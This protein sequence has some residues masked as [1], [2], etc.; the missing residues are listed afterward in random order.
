MSGLTI[1]PNKDTGKLELTAEV[2]EN[3]NRSRVIDNFEVILFGLKK[4]LT[5]KTTCHK[6]LISLVKN[7]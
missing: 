4:F 2:N 3:V 7:I 6:I 5:F 1:R